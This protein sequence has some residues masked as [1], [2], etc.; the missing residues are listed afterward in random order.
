MNIKIARYRNPCWKPNG[1]GYGPEFYETE[2]KPV[3][4]AGHLIYERIE[5]HVWD[6]VRDGVCVTQMAGLNGA[7]RAA[8]GAMYGSPV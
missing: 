4:H 7:K 1:R 6:V 5:G 8:E 3:E 2:A